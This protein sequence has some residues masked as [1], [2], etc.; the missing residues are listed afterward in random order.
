MAKKPEH[1]VKLKIWTES[2]LASILVFGVIWLLF[3]I[4]N[5]TFKPFNYVAKALKEVQLTDIYF[6]KLHN[7][8]AD[9][10]IILV[11]IEDLDRSGIA[12][13][14][15]IINSDCPKVIAIDVFF[16][17]H[18]DKAGDSLLADAFLSAGSKIVLAEFYNPQTNKPDTAY[19]I[20]NNYDYG[21]ADLPNNEDGTEVVR[22]F[23]PMIKYNGREMWAFSAMVARKYS[24]ERFDALK[25]RNNQEELINYIGDIN[26]YARVSY[27]EIMQP[28]QKALTLFKD[29]IVI[30]GFAGGKCRTTD[31][32]EDLFYTPVNP[33]YYGRAHPDMFGM[34]IHANIVSM[35][36]KGSYIHVL[37]NWLVILISFII[38]YL[39]VAFFVWLFVKKHIWYHL[40]VKL[41]QL[42]SFS[43]ILLLIFYLFRLTSVLIYTKYMLLGVILSADILYFYEALAL[44]GNKWLGI[45]SFFVNHH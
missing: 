9:T 16:S 11:N 13:L 43:L 7:D 25:A 18:P 12:R 40:S 31:D 30:L 28:G 36:L 26:S 15:N 24:P 34:V 45:K 29:K 5:I 27:S 32:M 17:K 33:H 38:V 14:I 23:T 39:H 4:I 3:Y 22:D 19:K 42:F 10:N 37:P 44:F 6:S 8:N 41:I 21:H 2:F 35:I 20:F 1:S